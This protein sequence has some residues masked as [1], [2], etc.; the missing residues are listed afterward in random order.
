MYC[1]IIRINS[2]QFHPQLQCIYLLSYFP[3]DTAVTLKILE[4]EIST[5]NC[6]RN[7]S[8]KFLIVQLSQY[9]QLPLGEH[10]CIPKY[11]FIARQQKILATVPHILN[12]IDLHVQVR[13]SQLKK[14]NE[15]INVCLYINSIHM[16][17]HIQCINTHTSIYSTMLW[18]T[19]NVFC[20]I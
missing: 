14:K 9:R 11:L 16:Q 10:K 4:F 18:C 17:R 13:A 1:N 7:S 3:L 19:E 2:F 12:F 5:V 15:C 8:V 20:C 6:C